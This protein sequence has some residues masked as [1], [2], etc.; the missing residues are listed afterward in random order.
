M[1]YVE[2]V[3]AA[4][5]QFPVGNIAEIG[6]PGDQDHRRLPDAEI[7]P[8]GVGIGH[9]PPW[10][11]RQIDRALRDFLQIDDLKHRTLMRVANA[12]GNAETHAFDDHGAVRPRPRWEYGFDFVGR[13][14]QPCDCRGTAIC[15][16]DLSIICDRTRNPRKSGQRR[17]VLLPVMVDDLDTIARSV[18]DKD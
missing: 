16:Q 9:A 11:P 18:R 1:V 5:W 14:V 4:R 6:K 7:Y 8:P 3:S 13:G 15:G 17:D 10:T 12:R 2:A